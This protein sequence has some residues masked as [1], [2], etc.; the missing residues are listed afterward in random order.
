MT[1]KRL[2]TYTN[3]GA[4]YGPVDAFK[5]AA[6]RAALLTRRSLSSHGIKEV[7][8]SRG[9]SAYVL[10]LSTKSK[11]HQ[12]IAH[13]EEALGTK[14]L[15]ADALEKETGTTYYDAIAQDTVAM[16]VND[17]IVSGLLPVSVAMHLS[18][19]DL[20]WF[21]NE[22]RWKA[23]V[24]GWKKACILSQAVWGPGE[25]PIPNK[26]YGTFNLSG[27]AIGIGAYLTRRGPR[28]GNS[29]VLIESSG[30]HANG[31][32]LARAVADSVSKKYTSL[33]SNGEMYGESLLKPTHIY[34]PL[35][36]ACIKRKIRLHYMVNITGHGW[37]K[38]MRFSKPY[39][40]EMHTLPPITPL[41]SFIKTE[42]P[43]E[44]KEMY[45]TFNMGAGFAI[46]TSGTRES[47]EI[48]SLAKSLKL[49]AWE[50]G[51]VK[52]SLNGRKV[53][54][55]KPLAIRFEEDSLHIR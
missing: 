30:I 42:G 10:A 43:V 53:V 22:K 3:T 51:V 13:V 24:R 15:V 16:I 54:H 49:K 20:N 18:T 9:D 34:V 19:G 21:Q 31:L 1:R 11:K 12:N 29:I 39:H 55:L 41:F 36:A 38:L 28:A 40:Y 2:M 14:H 35:V 26:T 27:S 46:F 50:A 7:A 8:E 17:L 47:K 33:L 48:I 6:Q 37:R 45:G 23:L 4:D 52:R 25:T 5:R 32:T 44:L